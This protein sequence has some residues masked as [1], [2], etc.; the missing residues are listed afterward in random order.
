MTR[1]VGIGK[2]VWAL[3]NELIH[4]ELY[5]FSSLI[6]NGRLDIGLYRSN[7]NRILVGSDNDTRV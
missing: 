4:C 7:Q 5:I 6:M 1:V 2:D 3:S